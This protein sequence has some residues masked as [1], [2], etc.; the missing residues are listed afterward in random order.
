MFQAYD[1][2]AEPVAEPVPETVPEAERRR[3]RRRRRAFVLACL[4]LAAVPTALQIERW[5]QGR[6]DALR[7]DGPL[8]PGRHGARKHAR[9]ASA[10]KPAALNYGALREG[11]L[12]DLERFGAL[13]PGRA[14]NTP[15]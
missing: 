5:G 9:T 10:A 7:V 13:G 15:T 11:P 8:G 6:L 1:V 2:P 3:A 14:A 4:I 12:S